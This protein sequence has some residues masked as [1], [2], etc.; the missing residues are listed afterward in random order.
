MSDRHQT[1][2]GREPELAN[3]EALLAELDVA[4]LQVQAPPPEVWAGI[5]RTLEEPQEDP[6]DDLD[7]ARLR[8]RRVLRFTF[9]AA[10]A[11]LLIIAFSVFPFRGNDST[12]VISAAELAHDTGFD[13]LGSDASARAELVEKDGFL[14]IRLTDLALPDVEGDE[15]EL[16]LIE[17]DDSGTPVDVAPVSVVDA[18]S[19]G[20][21]RLPADLDPAT[22]AIV[23][24]SIEPR[25][26]DPTHSGRS[27]LRGTLEPV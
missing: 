17:A 11:V 1:D 8:R 22:H 24:I 12:Q 10:A 5:E 21:Y 18:A 27:I 3:V 4:D 7:R 19:S 13:P 6:G 14:S 26:G 15:L 2:E 23:D 20:T 25:D 16:W 9:A